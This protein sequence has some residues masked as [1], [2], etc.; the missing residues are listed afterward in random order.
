[1]P[2]INLFSLGHRQSG[3]RF[4]V[5]RREPPAIKY[6]SRHDDAA[7]RVRCNPRVGPRQLGRNLAHTLLPMIELD[8]LVDVAIDGID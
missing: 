6:S 3:E 2:A 1:V 7:V 4:A 5:H 8:D